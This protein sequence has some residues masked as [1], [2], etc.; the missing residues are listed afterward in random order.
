M[1]ILDLVVA[2]FV[3]VGMIVL[4]YYLQKILSYIHSRIPEWE[5]QF[6]GNTE[7]KGIDTD[8]HYIS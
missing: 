6:F 8:F 5:K 7:I 4:I 3:A 1:I 2:V